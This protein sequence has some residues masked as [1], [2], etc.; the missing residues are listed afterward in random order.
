MQKIPACKTLEKYG[1]SEQDWLDLYN[2]YD[3][4]CHVCRKPTKGRLNIEHEH[5]KG[6][7]NMLPEERKKYVRGLADFVCNFRILTRGTTIEKLKLAVQYLEEYE[8]R[9]SPP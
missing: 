1:L 3:G 8:K 9:K 2:K 7:K 4:R 6:F 5:V